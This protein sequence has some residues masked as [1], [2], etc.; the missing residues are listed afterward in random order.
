MAFVPLAVSMAEIADPALV[1]KY[2][3]L[4]LVL[5]WFMLRADKRLA[6]IEHKIGGLNRTML[7]EI[8][9]RPSTGEKARQ[10]CREELRKV[11]PRLADEAEVE[12]ERR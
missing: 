9:S 4:G 10:A 12:R 8:L 3:I 1:E 7:I 11:D 5:A 6:G 2:G